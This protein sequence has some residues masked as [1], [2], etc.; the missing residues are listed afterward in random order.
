MES[1]LTS[2]NSNLEIIFQILAAL[3]CGLSFRITLSISKQR[4]AT[5]FH[6]TLT[7]LLLPVIT[8]IIT[9]V[10]SG[11]IALSLGMIGALSIVR[12]RNPVKNPFEL[13]MFFALITI[14]ISISAHT[15]WGVLLTVVVNIVILVIYYSNYFLRKLNINFF[16][17]S[18]DEGNHLYRLEIVS[19]SEIHKLFSYK[20]IMQYAEDRE[21]NEFFYRIAS[22]NLKDVENIKS[23]VSSDSNIKSIDINYQ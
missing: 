7:F 3:F 21:N 13:V 14:G 10:I 9:K 15:K 18:F 19:S 5:T 8:L 16:N 1:I 12:F 6:Q 4:W 2:I 11:N 17:I 22:N 23:L 20:G